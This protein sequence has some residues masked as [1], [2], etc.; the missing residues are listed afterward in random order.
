MK[1]IRIGVSLGDPAGIGAEIT[2]KAILALRNEPIEFVLFCDDRFFEN[3]SLGSDLTESLL[4]TNLVFSEYPHLKGFVQAGFASPAGGEFAYESLIEGIKAALAKHVDALVTAP[5]S[6]QSLMLSGHPFRGHTEILQSETASPFVVMM[7]LAGKFRVVPITRHVPIKDVPSLIKEKLIID[8]IR[9]VAGSLVR[10]EGISK[11]TIGALALNPHAGE[12][13]LFGNEEQAILS[14]IE[15][16]RS[17]GYDVE[18]PLVPDIAFIPR[19]RVRFDAIIGMFH[20]Q[21]LIPLKMAGFEYGVNATLGLPF[22]RTSPDHGTAFDIAGKDIA[23]PSSMI[24]AI[25][26]AARWAK[27]IS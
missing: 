19:I 8:S 11:P 14:A 4:E 20:D 2:A 17:D 13:G 25:S 22:I 16:L 26:L 21:V 15:V 1:S 23:N 6:K 18:G 5:L 3:P 27:A 12:G 24:E 9:L 7:L 10:F